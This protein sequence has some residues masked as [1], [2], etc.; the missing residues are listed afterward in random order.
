MNRLFVALAALLPLWASAEAVDEMYP[1]PWVYEFDNSITTALV[2]A[3]VKGCGIYRY[4]VSR[5]SASEYLVYCSRDNERWKAY[6]VWPNINK[7]L[8]PY[9]PDPLLP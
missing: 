5:S 8:G 9:Q 2:R 6:L 3:K 1:S 7:V 4:R